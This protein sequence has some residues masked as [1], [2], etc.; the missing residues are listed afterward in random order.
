MRPVYIDRSHTFVKEQDKKELAKKLKNKK[1]G[2]LTAR[3]K[4]Q[5]KV[6]DIP[7]KAHQYKLFEPLSQLWQGYM[8]KLLSQGSAN[9]EQKLIKADFHG[10]TMTGKLPVTMTTT[11]GLIRSQLFRPPIL[12]TLVLLVL[13]FKKPCPCSRSSP[14]KTNLSVRMQEIHTQTHTHIINYI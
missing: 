11:V 8:S 6:Y 10:A 13:W 5:L 2:K 9:F 3:E 14:R 1:D 12:L 7:K 4:R